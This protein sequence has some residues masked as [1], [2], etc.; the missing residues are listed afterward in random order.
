M[1]KEHVPWAIELARFFGLKNSKFGQ[2]RKS[3]SWNMHLLSTYVYTYLHTLLSIHL[4]VT[5]SVL[6]KLSIFLKNR[7]CI[8]FE[9]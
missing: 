9:N 5:Y 8:R 7:E 2:K 1:V 4:K 6:K 3:K